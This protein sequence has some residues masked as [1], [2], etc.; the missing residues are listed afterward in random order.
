[1]NE[2]WDGNYKN[3]KP[4]EQAVYTYKVIVHNG[5]TGQKIKSGKVT[6]AR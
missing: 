3:G 2:G 6:L 5:N 1:M 4:A